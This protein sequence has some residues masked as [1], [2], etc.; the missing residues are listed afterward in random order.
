MNWT[1]SRSE[2]STY[3]K[4][5][6][7]TTFPPILSSWKTF[8]STMRPLRGGSQKLLTA[9]RTRNYPFRQKI[10]SSISNSTWESELTGS[11]SGQKG[12]ECLFARFNVSSFIFI[13]FILFFSCFSLCLPLLAN[14]PRRCSL[15]RCFSPSGWTALYCSLMYAYFALGYIWSLIF[16]TST[17]RKSI[18]VLTKILISVPDGIGFLIGKMILTFRQPCRSL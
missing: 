16:I 3:T 8:R 13:F 7:S 12:I 14:R 9:L 18:L 4:V 15:F 17:E 1:K 5:E 10:T 11:G 6:K 2:Q